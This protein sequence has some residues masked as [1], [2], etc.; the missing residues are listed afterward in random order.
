MRAGI[1]GRPFNPY[2][3]EYSIAIATMISMIDREYH[4]NH[5]SLSISNAS[6]YILTCNRQNLLCR[7]Q[8]AFHNTLYHV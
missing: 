1:L 4:R 3:L 5:E 7:N 6:S 8:I 2:R